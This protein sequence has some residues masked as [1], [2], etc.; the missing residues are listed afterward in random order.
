MSDVLA[1]NKTPSFVL[2]I[3]SFNLFLMAPTALML[4]YNSFSSY[5]CV[6]VCSTSA[7]AIKDNWNGT[8]LL[9]STLLG[10]LELL[11]LRRGFGKKVFSLS[12]LFE[13]SRLYSVSQLLMSIDNQLYVAVSGASLISVFLSK[14]FAKN[15]NEFLKRPVTQNLGQVIPAIVVILIF[16]GSSLLST[17]GFG[18]PSQVPDPQNFDTG[19]INWGIFKP[20]SWN[21]Q[22]YLDN[23]LDQFRAGMYDP[24]KPVFN[25]TNNS[26][27]PI[28]F[29][30]GN[31]KI[32]SYL[33]QET[34]FAYEYD[35]AKAKSGTFFPADTGKIDT[36]YYSAGQAYTGQTFSKPVPATFLDELTKPVNSRA[37]NVYNL[38]VTTLVNHTSLYD[39]SL[40]V[41][42][43]SR[44]YGVNGGDNNFYGSFINPNTTVV[45]N[46]NGIV[47]QCYPKT[48]ISSCAFKEDS[49]GIA[50]FPGVSDVGMRIDGFSSSAQNQFM[51]YS[52]NYLE[53]NYQYINLHSGDQAY[54]QS[55]CHHEIFDR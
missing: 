50:N 29:G 36:S 23:I 10:G 11:M 4:L 26:P 1:K 18:T 27:D 2:Y 3:L 54:Y 15:V 40:P 39:Q 48:S 52:M 9:G 16:T 45:Y 44:T 20:A 17:L 33:K 8:I 13:L 31:Q 22:Y 7:E 28:R 51:N 35:A 14:V 19:G 46:Q 43:N 53:P 6:I 47:A 37:Y 49:A 12:L 25:V 30:S 24:F 55:A 41:P 5:G 42:W 21:A 38:T 34:Y 32:S